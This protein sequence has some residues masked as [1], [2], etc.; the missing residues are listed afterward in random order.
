MHDSHGLCLCPRGDTAKGNH[1]QLGIHI[2]MGDG[3]DTSGVLAVGSDTRAKARHEANLIHSE[4]QKVFFASIGSWR[5]SRLA[6]VVTIAAWSN[7]ERLLVRIYSDPL[8]RL[9]QPVFLG[10]GRCHGVLLY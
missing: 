4:P 2:I 7:Q 6:R 3:D 9:G 10:F 1:P 8:E 5:D